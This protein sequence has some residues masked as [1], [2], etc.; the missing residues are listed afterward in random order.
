MGNLVVQLIIFAVST[1][2]QM[3]QQNKMK[4]KQAAAAKLRAEE[5]ESRKGFHFTHKSGDATSL[6]VVYGKQLLG[7]V[8][9]KLKVNSSHAGATENADNVFSTGLGTSGSGSKNE[10]LHAQYALC[11]D[12]IEGVNWV[13]VDSKHYNEA[14]AKFSHRIRIFN[15][16]GTA[17]A[18]STANGI[19]ATNTFTDTAFATATYKLNREEQNYSGPPDVQFMVKGRKLR[20]V[21]RSGTVGNYT[22]ALDTSYTYS[23]NPA[24]V[25]IDYLT[26]PNFGRGLSEDE[27]HLETF[28]KAATVCGT[29]VSTGRSVGGRINGTLPTRKYNNQSL[30]PATLTVEE[31]GYLYYDESNDHW[32]DATR[33]S[34]DGEQAATYT[35]RGLPGTRDIPLYECNITLDT[36]SNFRDNIERIMST[37]NMA[38]LVWSGVGKYKLLVD[39]PTSEAETLALIDSAHVFDEDSVLR[40]AVSINWP[41]AESRL[42]Q[43]TISY[44]DEHEDFKT[45][46]VSWP[47]R[48]STAHLQ[49]L[50]EDNDQPFQASASPDGISNP[51]HALAAAEHMV[52]QSRAMYTISLTLDKTGLNI[53]PGDLI[54]VNL[55]RDYLNNEIFRVESIEINSDFSV[56]ISAYHFSHEMLAWN[57]DDDIAYATDNVTDFTVDNVTNLAYFPV[58]DD[59]RENTLGI[60]SWDSDLTAGH[61]YDVFYRRNGET[62]FLFFS[63]TGAKF[64]DIVHLDNIAEGEYFDFCVKAV[65][66][67]GRRSEGTELLNVLI[68]VAPPEITALAVAEEQ[69]LT[70]NASG[71]KNRGIVTWNAG[72]GGLK[73][74]YYIVQYKRDAEATFQILGTTNTPNITIPD[75]SDGIYQFKV[76]PVSFLEFQGVPTILNKTI[77]GFSQAPAD[78]SGFTGNINEGQINLTWDSPTDLDV[79]YGGY[80]QI[81]FHVDTGGVASWDTSSIL[82]E[83]LSGNTTNKTV[84]TLKGTFFIRFY[85]AF[86]NFSDNPSSFVSTFVDNT[87]NQISVIDEDTPGFLGNKTNCTVVSSLLT[88]DSGE[89]SMEYDFDDYVDLQEQTT[90]RLVPDSDISVTQANTLVAN[91]SNVSLV[92]NFAGPIANAS[93]QMFVSITDNPPNTGTPTWSD[94]SLLT[95]G[96]YTC[97]GIRFRLKIIADDSNVAVSVS[98]LRVE[99]DKKDIIKTGTSQSSTTADTTVTFA[100]AYYAGIAGTAVPTIG[101]MTIGGSQGDN[102]VISSRSETGFSYSVY[103]TAARVQR[104]I[105]WQA[106]GQ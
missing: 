50:S 74:D 24:L 79:L 66:P 27:L 55:P 9:T 51:Y 87:F 76:T 19:P 13:K 45:N 89:S 33:A 46:S 59:E 96:S 101:V 65:S 70:N 98:R 61:A 44:Q 94:Y 32:F 86:D 1:A 62:D 18:A 48:N 26:N 35:L 90:V 2:Y 72:T 11:H 84:P 23:N 97:R 83:K 102:V 5:A 104:T 103:N 63:N 34:G 37:M 95:V 68:E 40:E 38:E 6:P 12:G 77:V 58:A 99:L 7:G 49:Y 22:Y 69:Y 57:V 36:R 29:T 80:S 39:Y 82:V 85:D 105:D 21:V 31:V 53:E 16:G 8:Q 60:V 10:F 25:L 43:A 17:C 92:D 71:L 42:N 56:K 75:I 15:D 52:R 91:Y 100:D 81:R 64:V 14:S 47:V 106:I 88:M 28:Y 3:S 73:T 41:S 93:I 30:F 20:A 78:P 67:F 54:K 4:K